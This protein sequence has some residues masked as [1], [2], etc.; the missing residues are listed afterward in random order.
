MLPK[1]G[2]Y[3]K[4]LTI[5]YK[6]MKMELINKTAEIYIPDETKFENALERTTVLCIAAHQ[7][8]IEI[9]AYSHIAKCFGKSDEWFTG[10]VVTDGGGSP[11]T[12]I[13]KNYSDDEMKKIRVAEQKQAAD[14]GRY[15][16]QFLL[17]YPSSEVKYS[18]NKSVVDDIKTIIE[19]CLPEVIL[20]H[21]L[22]DK[23]DTHVSVAIRVIEA[24]RIM[25]S[26]FIPENS[27]QLP[28]VYS[29]EVWRGLDWLT[30]RDKEAFDTSDHPNIAAALLGVFDS[31]IAG[32]KRYDLAS[33]GRRAANATFF[34][35]HDVDNSDSV[36]YG[37]DI[38]ELITD[39]EM[40]YE[41]FVKRHIKN[42]QDEVVEKIRRFR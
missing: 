42:F 13:Y 23:H 32:G 38:T 34:A 39:P 14:I 18:C 22:F 7:D 21:N 2:E 36:S 40:N 35:S 41:D 27:K 9:M 20:T 25:T 28:K 3:D 12:G 6:I 31:Q 15:S 26:E 16:A 37:I 19:K 10:V 30:D 8:D 24:L 11:R 17:G 1:K 5:S 29:M 4:L 33:V